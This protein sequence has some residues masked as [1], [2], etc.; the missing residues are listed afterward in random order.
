MKRAI[1]DIAVI[2]LI[3][4]MAAMPAVFAILTWPIL[5]VASLL[6]LVTYPAIWQWLRDYIGIPLPGEKP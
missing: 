4:L 2:T 3:I 5:G 1:T 6:S